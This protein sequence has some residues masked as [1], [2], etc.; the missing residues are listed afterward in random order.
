MTGDII[1][2]GHVKL[3]FV[4]PGDPYVFSPAD[5]EHVE[6]DQSSQL[7][8]IL[9]MVIAAAVA[10]FASRQFTSRNAGPASSP[11]PPAS[12]PDVQEPPGNAQEAQGGA[13]MNALKSTEGS[14][15]LDA[16]DEGE[17]TELEAGTQGTAAKASNGTEEGEVGGEVTKE[18]PTGGQQSSGEDAAEDEDTE[19]DTEEDAEDD[20]EATADGGQAEQN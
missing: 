7:K 11:L 19:E 9:I 15:S 3:R 2:L 1:T 5:V 8:P 4:A 14:S 16:S 12:S 10:W 13:P 17:A 18:E 20:G 6:I